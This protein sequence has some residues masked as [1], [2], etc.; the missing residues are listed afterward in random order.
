MDDMH[1]WYDVGGSDDIVYWGQETSWYD[2]DYGF[3]NEQ[4]VA[5]FDR[6]NYPSNTDSYI[7]V[8]TCIE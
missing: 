5:K 1:C 2:G 7:K 3:G 4:W 6:S 8:K